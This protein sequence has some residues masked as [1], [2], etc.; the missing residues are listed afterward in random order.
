MARRR[1][2][3]VRSYGNENWEFNEAGLMTHR[4]ASINDLPIND[5]RCR[6]SAAH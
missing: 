6:A 3:L 4:N 5:R 2:Q 1:R